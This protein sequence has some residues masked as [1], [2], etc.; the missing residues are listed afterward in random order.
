MDV[1]DEEVSEVCQVGQSAR[2]VIVVDRDIIQLS[3]CADGVR[4]CTL[5][6]IVEKVEILETSH[7]GNT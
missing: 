6:L 7:C 5:Q 4:N 2:E 1:K 3:Q